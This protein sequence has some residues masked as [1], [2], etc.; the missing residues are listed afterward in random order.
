MILK[1]NKLTMEDNAKLF[2][3]SIKHFKQ[4]GELFGSLSDFDFE[5]S[6][7][8]LSALISLPLD[9]ISKCVNILSKLNEPKVSSECRNM[10]SF[11]D[12]E[13]WKLPSLGSQ[14]DPRRKVMTGCT[15]WVRLIRSYSSARFASN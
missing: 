9:I 10:R 2:K 6:I 13:K 8:S 4:T 3:T 11:C 5:I 14:T 7:L 1:K 12:M 15:G